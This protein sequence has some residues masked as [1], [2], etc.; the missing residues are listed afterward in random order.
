MT[1][2]GTRSWLASFLRP[3]RHCHSCHHHHCTVLFHH[4][5]STPSLSP[6]QGPGPAVSER[7]NVPGVPVLWWGDGQ[8]KAANGVG[9]TWWMADGG[10]MNREMGGRGW[11]RGH[12]TRTVAWG[13]PLRR[14]CCGC[15]ALL[16]PS[17][18]LSHCQTWSP[19]HV[20]SPVGVDDVWGTGLGGGAG[21][22]PL[23]RRRLCTD[24]EKGGALWRAG[25]SALQAA[26]TARAQACTGHVFK[27]H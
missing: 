8:G 25:E 13:P 7:G 10:K 21:K 24:L 16:S 26:G 17:E 12:V 14:A 6:F 27:S 11:L 22:G 15:D 18:I 2:A 23:G 5:L 20:G 9:P 4:S 1:S 3:H 19:N